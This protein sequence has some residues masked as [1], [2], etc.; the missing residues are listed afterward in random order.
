MLQK[1]DD[2]LWIAEDPLRIFG[3]ALGRRMTVIGLP[4]GGLFL[5][6]P[7][8]MTADRKRRLL[9]LG[10]VRSIVA[11]GRFH[12]LYLD[13]ALLEFPQ[14]EL[15][16]IPSLFGRFTSRPNTFPLSDSP[17]SSWGEAIEQHAFIAGPFHSETVFFHRKSRSLLLTDLCFRLEDR[18]GMTRLAGG[19]LGVYQKFSPT[20]D[21]RLWTLGERRLLRDSV[22]RVLAWPFTRIIPAHG[23]RIPEN[24]RSAFEAAFR[25]VW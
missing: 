2:T 7:W 17:P 1:I 24:G 9:D 25:W 6:S 12:D 20:R 13:Q 21:I 16:A 22:E 14:A 15:H 3:I 18:G 4:D 8:E 19:I 23:E 11:P 5:H 10:P